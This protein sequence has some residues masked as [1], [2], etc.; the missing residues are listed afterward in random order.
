MRLSIEC[1]RRLLAGLALCLCGFLASPI[2]MAERLAHG[3]IVKLR[4]QGGAPG[5]ATMLDVR[6]VPDPT[7]RTRLREVMSRARLPAA[8]RASDTA[9]AAHVLRGRH[10]TSYSSALTEARRLRQDPNVAWAIVNEVETTQAATTVPTDPEFARQIWLGDSNTG[11]VPNIPAAWDRLSA[12]GRGLSPIVVAVLDTG[13]LRHPDLEGRVLF[14][15]GYDFVTESEYSNDGDGLDADASDPGSYL[16][17]STRAANRI[18]YSDCPAT[19]SSW[20]GTIIAGQLAAAAN[21]GQ[22]VAGMLLPM[23][24]VPVLPVRV[25][26]NCGAAVSDIIEGLLWSAGVTYTGMPKT[27][28]YPARVINLSFGG[29]ES[30]GCTLD[31]SGAPSSAGCIYQEAIRAITRRGAILVASS[32]N[33]TNGSTD[34]LATPARP[35]NC[36]GVLGVTALRADGAK[37]RYAYQVGALGVAT[38]GGAGDGSSDTILSTSNS[39]LTSPV[40]G[41]DGRPEAYYGSRD[42][43]S[44]SAPIAS[45]AVA[46]MWAINPGL[47]VTE[48]LNGLRSQGVRPHVTVSESGTALPLCAPLVSGV[49]NCAASTCGAGILD[50][51][52]ALAWAASQTLKTFTAPAVTADFFTPERAQMPPPPKGG[53]SGGGALS[54]ME[55]FAGL[56]LIMALVGS[57]LFS[58]RPS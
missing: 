27:N 12:L 34:G 49:C 38:L 36:P 51:E 53:N 48:V 22:G 46:L 54:G 5:A 17:E 52:K 35:A 16:Q 28:H 45:G 29:S 7:M 10:P 41:S 58:C 24:H 19:N 23:T 11:G 18:A 43:T 3:V 30:C 1:H 40:L 9:F 14:D 31:A 25:S 32:G 15:D 6:A 26:G 39:G 20:H 37:A 8:Y 55:L 50:V 4:D 47:T 13:V 57:R 44:F 33:A 21:N 56:L 2:A 42:G